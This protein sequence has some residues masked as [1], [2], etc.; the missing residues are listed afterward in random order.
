MLHTGS[1]QA[2]LQLSVTVSI[3]ADAPTLHVFESHQIA[4]Q[5]TGEFRTFRVDTVED[6]PLSPMAPPSPGQPPDPFPCF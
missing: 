3:D 5:G 2:P 6:E 4:A 1:P